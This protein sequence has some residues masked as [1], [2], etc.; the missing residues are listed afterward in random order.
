MPDNAVPPAP[1]GPAVPPKRI[2]DN[3]RDDQ[4]DVRVNP[5]WIPL[6]EM[7]RSW[8]TE[9][10]EG[11]VWLYSAVP[12]EDPGQPDAGRWR[13]TMGSE[14]IFTVLPKEVVDDL[15]SAVRN[16]RAERPD[17][18]I[19]ELTE[20]SLR[21]GMQD[22][23]H[24]TVA[25]KFNAD[26]TT[27]A[28]E[29]ALSGEFRFYPEQGRA[30]IN[31]K[32]GRYMSKAAR[33]DPRD[34]EPARVAE[35]GEALA[36]EF[37]ARLDVPVTFRQTKTLAAHPVEPLALHTAAALGQPGTSATAPATTEHR[38]VPAPA[39]RPARPANEATRRRR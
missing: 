4:N 3:E 10:R 31:D 33:P 29:A 12:C 37:E 22:L 5:L 26:G 38:T 15:L 18:N 30:E 35:W 28:G 36:R 2:K 6:D 11:A 14:E 1:F 21:A 24:P 20:D 25:V 39:P 32:S 23:G 8:V 19:P 16:L 7:P 34:R 17:D 9:G 13:V 27:A